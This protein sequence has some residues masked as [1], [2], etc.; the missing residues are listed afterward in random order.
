VA[1]ALTNPS[2]FCPFGGCS[3]CP[4]E[5]AEAWQQDH[6][7]GNSGGVT[8]KKTSNIKKQ[9]TSSTIIGISKS[10]F[11]PISKHFH[12]E[13]HLKKESYEPQLLTG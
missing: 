2:C 11:L 12:F 10:Y 9:S 6:P 1:Q 5:Q 13:P 4:G 7:D 8:N 3:A